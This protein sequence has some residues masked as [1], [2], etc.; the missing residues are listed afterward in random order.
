[1]KHHHHHTSAWQSKPV[2][3]RNVY[4]YKHTNFKSFTNPQER[5]LDPGNIR[6][7]KVQAPGAT[8]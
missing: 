2:F 4:L 8:T 5:G 1:M 7:D 6:R 3:K